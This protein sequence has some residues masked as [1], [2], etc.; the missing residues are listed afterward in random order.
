MQLLMLMPHVIAKI[1]AIANRILIE[2][3]NDFRYL[4]ITTSNALK[5]EEL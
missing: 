3:S 2:V 5:F 4:Q 1:N